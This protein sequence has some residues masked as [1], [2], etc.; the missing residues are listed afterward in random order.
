ML[1]IHAQL[2]REHHQRQ[3]RGV[4]DNG[5]VVGN[6]GVAAENQAIGEGW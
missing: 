6:S 5:T 1:G 4:T 2:G 3:L